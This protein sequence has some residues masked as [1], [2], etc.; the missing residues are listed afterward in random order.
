MLLVGKWFQEH[1]QVVLSQE[2]NDHNLNYNQLEDSPPEP[3]VID[4]TIV[5]GDQLRQVFLLLRVKLVLWVEGVPR[6]TKQTKCFLEHIQWL[7]SYPTY[8]D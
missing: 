6:D 3:K 4:L 1:S 5:I 7:V 2:F 8:E